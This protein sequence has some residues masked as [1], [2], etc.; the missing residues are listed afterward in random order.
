[1]PASSPS[2]A[3]RPA[4]FATVLGFAAVQLDGAMLN[5]AVVE[6]G[7]SLSTG[8]AALPWI[9]NGYTLAFVGLLVA[10]GAIGDRIG[11]R[12]V[13]LWGFGIFGAASAAAA[14][15]PTVATL[16]AARVL[17]GAGGALLVPSSLALLNQ[18]CRG[19]TAARARAVGAWTAAG[20]IAV[21][22]GPA[23]SG[24][25]VSLVGWRSVFLVSAAAALPGL[26]LAARTIEDVPPPAT[27]P[28]RFDWAGQVLATVA[29]GAFVLAVIAAGSVGWWSGYF[30]AT[31]VA[32]VAGA[33]GFVRVEARATHPIA[34]PVLF[35][36]PQVGAMMAAGFAASFAIFG[37]VFGLALY[38][39]QGRGFGAL[40]TGLAFVPFSL[41]IIAANLA[42]SHAAARFGAHRVLVAGLVVA[43]LGTVSL[44][45]RLDGTASYLEELPAQFALRIGIGLAVPTATMLLL[46]AA[47]PDASGVASGAFTAVR[48][49]GAAIGVATYGILM[50]TDIVG[51]LRLSLAIS[52]ALLAT[53]LVLAVAGFRQRPDRTTDRR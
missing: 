19:D 42:G 4:V 51:G 47:P 13:F 41:A 3:P 15:A 40:E 29:L 38:F 48:Q 33:V 30:A 9:V 43:V 35:R 37:L 1:M 52:A 36:D 26:W 34:P 6:I 10:A 46:A 49:A 27:P 39:Q 22:V 32:A 21:A 2:S 17:Q 11:P 20:G 53:A 44:L 23:A 28:H 16:V 24:L 45:A 7:R 50:A 25:L 8:V 31:A 18:A 5:V 14:L 12:R